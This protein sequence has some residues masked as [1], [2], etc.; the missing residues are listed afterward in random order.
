MKTIKKPFITTPPNLEDI[1]GSAE[2]YRLLKTYYRF[3]FT[4]FDRNELFTVMKKT[5]KDNERHRINAI[6][7]L[8]EEF[9]I[10]C[11]GFDD[12]KE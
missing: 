4:I 11:V 7:G 6:V 8:F 5:F 1:I 9:E 2:N 12:K 10:K 3:M